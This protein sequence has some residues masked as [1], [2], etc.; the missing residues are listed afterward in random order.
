VR[1]GVLS[2]VHGN[3]HALRAAL[4]VGR[5]QGVEAW[6]CAGDLVGY[7][8][9][10]NECVETIASLGA[11]CVV[12]NHDLMALGLLSAEGK[13]PLVR[14]TQR[15]TRDVLGDD[16]RSYLLA[17]GR[18]AAAPGIVMAHGSLDDPEEYVATRADAARQLRQLADMDA[19]ARILVLGHTHHRE[20]FREGSG[21]ARI[22]RSGTVPLP[23]PDRWLLNPG[24]VGQSRQ[25]ERE[26][27]ARFL[28]LDTDTREA[29]FQ[30][31][32]Y[33]LAGCRRALQQRGLPTEVLHRPRRPVAGAVRRARRAARWIVERAGR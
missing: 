26:P 1:Y 11:T 18:T 8:P 6:L 7:G 28:V 15:W 3:L 5:E 32:S 21:R 19:S 25:I 9:H 13:S 12:G 29:R 31:L 10:P 4:G 20:A 27:R 16:T 24:S 30:R 2:D 22:P 23:P 17:L 33:D 14:L